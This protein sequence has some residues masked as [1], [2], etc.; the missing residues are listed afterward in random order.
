MVTTFYPPYHFGGD[1]MYIYRL[2]NEL[3]KRGHHVDVIHCKDAYRVLENGGPKGDFPNHPNVTVYPMKS[4]AGFLSP[5]LT[6]QTGM[7]FL[8]NHVLKS[9]LNNNGYDVIHYHNMSLIGIKAL[10]YGN[11][12]K[13]YT[14]HEHWL[15][16]PMHVLW[17]YNKGVCK[18]R[19]C[20]SCQLFGKRPPQLWRYTGLLEEMVQNVDMFISPSR[21]TKTKHLELGLDIPIVHIPY[22]L[23]KPDQSH[24]RCTTEKKVPNNRPYFLFVGRL[25]KIKGLQ[26]VIPLFKTHTQYDLLIA[27]DGEYEQILKKEAKGTANVKFLGR[28][29]HKTLQNLYRH[30]LAVVV[31][32]ICYEV[33][34]IIIIEAFSMETPVIVNNFG[35][36]PEVIEDSG[37]GFVYAD[38]DELI[39]A[40]ERLAHN[41]D[42]RN[43]LGRKGFQA[44]LDFWSEDS[45]MEQ[46]L[47]LINDLRN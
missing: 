43:D 8:K 26:N 35:A 42:L 29:D 19:N 7:P 5:L 1:A 33:F 16:C 15:V 28:L 20:L 3:A 31:P 46:Y 21:F 37:G 18:K 10:A 22:F 45:H 13:L 36:M 25:E 41:S 27:G 14:T 34:G 44:F 2:S 17:K 38:E 9:K 11:A 4:R 40:M 12:V 23:P 39:A 47:N 30:A 32:S 24:V 6:Q